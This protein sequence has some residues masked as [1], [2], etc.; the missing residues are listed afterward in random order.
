MPGPQ[1]YCQTTM[2][3][4]VYSH[5]YTQDSTTFIN[6][7]ISLPIFLYGSSCLLCTLQ[8][9]LTHDTGPSEK[10]KTSQ[11]ALSVIR[12]LRVQRISVHS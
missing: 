3:R 10:Q 6:V 1:R 2:D 9:K 4:Y 12:I 8:E 11:Q 7:E 5:D